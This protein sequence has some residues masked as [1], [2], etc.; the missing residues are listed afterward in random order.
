MSEEGGWP[1]KEET[2]KQREKREH[3]E[4]LKNLERYKDEVEYWRNKS[5]Q[6]ELQKEA[7]SRFGCLLMLG[8]ICILIILFS[9]L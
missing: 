3:R 4:A 1:Y 6:E 7:D 5:E 9:L 2:D 8:I